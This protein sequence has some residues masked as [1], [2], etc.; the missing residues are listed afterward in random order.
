MKTKIATRLSDGG[1]SPRFRRPNRT[2]IFS[3]FAMFGFSSLPVMLI[4]PRDTENR[5]RK[6]E[7]RS[8]KI[9]IDR[10]LAVAF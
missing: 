10:K 7:T 4:T 5:G 1:N 6:F 3:V 2:Q 8:E 9:N